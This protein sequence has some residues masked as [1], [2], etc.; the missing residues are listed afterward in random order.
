MVF[1]QIIPPNK[2]KNKKQISR[3]FLIQKVICMWE[4]SSTNLGRRPKVCASV[5]LLKVLAGT[6]TIGSGPLFGDRSEGHGI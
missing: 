1:S 6:S 5:G 2:Q 3:S 4:F